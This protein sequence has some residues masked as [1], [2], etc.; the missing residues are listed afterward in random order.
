MSKGKSKKAKRAPKKRG[1]PSWRV[2]AVLAG[3]LVASAAG[4]AS[5][6]NSWET[7]HDLSVIGNG[8][9]TIVQIHDPGCP[10]CRT[11]K[12][13][14]ETA[15]TRSGEDIQFRVASIRTPEGRSLQRRHDVPHVTLLFFEPDGTLWRTLTGVRSVESLSRAISHFVERSRNSS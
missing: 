4:L 11:L 5:Y 7:A 12:S 6:K 9:R 10:L 13:N 14:T 2:L 1:F 8:I 3:L 15:L